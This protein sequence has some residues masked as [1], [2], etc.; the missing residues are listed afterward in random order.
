MSSSQNLENTVPNAD[1]EKRPARD[2]AG[3]SVQ[4]LRVVGHPQRS[5]AA[6]LAA[7]LDF[8]ARAAVGPDLKSFS[9]TLFS[10]LAPVSA[11]FSFSSLAPVP[12]PFSLDA[13]LLANGPHAVL[14]TDALGAGGLTDER[15]GGDGKG[16]DRKGVQNAHQRLLWNIMVDLF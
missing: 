9:T 15:R 6:E 12:A 11:P 3:R 14:S 4:E 1:Q 2:G 7:D 13:T 16:R 5:P 10:S 8:D